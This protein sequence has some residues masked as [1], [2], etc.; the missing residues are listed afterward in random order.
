[1]R[2]DLITSIIAVLSFT[3]LLG[4]GYPLVVT[5]VAQMTMGSKAD[6]SRIERDGTIVGS[7]LIAQAPPKGDAYFVPRPSQTDYAAN[8]SSFRNLGPNS[9]ELADFL[10]EQRDAYLEREG[11]HVD[12]LH[13]ADIPVDA[14]TNSAS[15]IDPH[16]SIANARI[17]AHRVADE[18]D[19][20]LRTVLRIVDRHTTGRAFGVFGERGVNVLE[21]NL[22]LDEEFP[23]R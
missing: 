19:I 11:G 7:R 10:E 21:V 4:V 18:R 6:G 15:G 9:R 20:S 12:D 2:R 23:V 5:A 17:Q 14:V 13:A 22:D 1:M 8:G 16:I 3:L